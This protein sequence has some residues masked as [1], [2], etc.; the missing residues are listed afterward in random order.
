MSPSVPLFEGDSCLPFGCADNRRTAG[1]KLLFFCLSIDEPVVRS[2]PLVVSNRRTIDLRFSCAGCQELAF[3]RIRT[4]PAGACAQFL[5]S[6][7]VTHQSDEVGELPLG[8]GPIPLLQ[9]SLTEVE[10]RASIFGVEL[11]GILIRGT[12]QVVLCLRVE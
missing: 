3:V 6:G 5:R 12:R 1:Q 4:V 9:V 2:R 8:A 10:S 11:E 7:R